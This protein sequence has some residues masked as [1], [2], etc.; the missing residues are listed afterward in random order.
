[1]LAQH[2]LINRGGG[3]TTNDD[4]ANV[5]LELIWAES[6]AVSE[7]SLM[8]KC[9]HCI[10]QCI[11][12]VKTSM[13]TSLLTVLTIAVATFLLGMFLVVLH[14][15]SVRLAESASG[16]SVMVFF[17]DGVRPE[18][19]NVV[20]AVVRSSSVPA[21]MTVVDKSAALERF[22]RALGE[23]AAALDG[24][25]AD[26]PLPMSLQITVRTPSDVESVY[27]SLLDQI[28]NEAF[29]DAVRYSQN[30]VAYM[31]QLVEGIRFAG[32]FCLVLIGVVVAFVISNT[33]RLALFNHRQ[34]IE[35]M[36]LI[37]ASRRGIFAPFL[38]E[39]WLQGACG[40]MLGVMVL[41]VFMVPLEELLS[42]VEIVRLMVPKVIFIP[43]WQV[44]GIVAVGIIVGTVGS[45]MAVRSFAR[46]K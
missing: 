20:K 26:N 15:A 4:T 8:G 14:N 30:D 2:R 7:I 6:G 21:T 5:G 45:L 28:A 37:G 39:G 9:Y 34:E 11:Q 1:M 36:R 27:S 38:L 44:L 24:L 33:I 46:D 42:Q 3:M 40:A 17:N 18:E 10:L 13:V 41:S 29:V 35:I 23:D 32:G 22:R 25:E 43:L 19:I 16:L 12:N 31:R